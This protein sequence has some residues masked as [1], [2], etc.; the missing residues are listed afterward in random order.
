M[1]IAGLRRAEAM[2]GDGTY[3]GGEAPGI[4]D[5]CL[6]PQVY[7]ARRF[8]VPLDSYPRLL[9]IDAACMELEAFRRAS[10]CGEIGV[11]RWLVGVC[12]LALPAVAMAQDEYSGDTDWTTA[13]PVAFHSPY[14]IVVRGGLLQRNDGD[15]V[16]DSAILTDL[17]PG[18]GVRVENR[19]RDEAGLV[20]SAAPTVA[21]LIQP[22]TVSPCVVL[23]AMRRG[24]ALV[25]L[26]GVPQAD[27]F[28]GWVAWSAYDAINLG[29]AI[30][31][32]GGGSRVDG[33]GALAGTV[34]LYSTITDGADAKLRL[35]WPTKLGRFGI[36]WRQ[37]RHRRRCD[38]WS[39]WPR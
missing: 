6:V 21:A 22:V 23:A 27:P 17:L 10:R 11:I 33:P 5:C 12:A 19:L 36:G 28:S 31:A 38:R 24:R 29:G 35:W 13:D 15:L 30:I 32:R 34:G 2:A 25:T 7:N 39:L 18:L 26:D 9:A 16:Q 20:S 37:G 1:D 8:E 4:A 3:L 14:E